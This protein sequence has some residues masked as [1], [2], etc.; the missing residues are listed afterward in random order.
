MENFSPSFC[1][2]AVWFALIAFV[3]LLPH[4]LV[5][6]LA[7][8]NA[9]TQKNLS[10]HT[11]AANESCKLNKSLMLRGVPSHVVA[12]P[13]LGAGCQQRRRRRR[14]R[15]SA[16]RSCFGFDWRWRIECTR[17]LNGTCWAFNWRWAPFNEA[18]E[19]A[20]LEGCGLNLTEVVKGSRDRG[21]GRREKRYVYLAEARQACWPFSCD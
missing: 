12:A 7:S 11:S 20:T 13:L 14:R 16:Q 21:N 6:R 15:C 9:H 5:A 19:C 1:F 10:P 17:R 18:V 3:C 2:L 8:H 4:T